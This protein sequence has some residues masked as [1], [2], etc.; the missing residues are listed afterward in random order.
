MA[1]KT[2]GLHTYTGDE[3]SNILI[4]QAGFDIIDQT[5]N[6]GEFHVNGT[7][8]EH[9]STSNLVSD[10]DGWISIKVL[11]SSGVAFQA[12]NACEG[13]DFGLDGTYDPDESD[14]DLT[15]E[16][17]DTIYGHFTHIAIRTANGVLLAYRAKK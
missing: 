12:K 10:S 5:E 8:G 4:G 2:K 7:T 17:G 1:I 15:L 14:N 9:A 13:D 3:T 11:G 16:T 6:N